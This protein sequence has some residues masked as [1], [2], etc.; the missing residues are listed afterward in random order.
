[1]DVTTIIMTTVLLLTLFS[2]FGVYY[3]MKKARSKAFESHRKI[4]NTIYIVCVLGVLLL[5]GLIRYSGGSGSLAS[6]SEYYHT[7]FFKMTL[8]SHIIVAVLTYLLWTVLI[9]LSNVRF[10]K[11]LPGKFSNFHKKCGRVIFAGLVYTAVTAL[12]VYLMSLNWV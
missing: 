3:A 2:P 5:E 4:Q 10:K 7:S 9:I 6:E 11:N 8:Y 1:M 12:L